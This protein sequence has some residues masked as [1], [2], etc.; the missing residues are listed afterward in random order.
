MVA[1]SLDSAHGIVIVV[2][3]NCRATENMDILHLGEF[4][5]LLGCPVAA[6]LAV[7][8]S[9]MNPDAP[10]AAELDALSIELITGKTVGAAEGGQHVQYAQLV[11]T[12]GLTEDP[13][14]I[15]CDLI[16]S[17]SGWNPNVHLHS[18]SGAKPA[19]DAIRWQPNS[20]PCQSS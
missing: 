15:D 6:G 20:M 18:Q 10:L 9:R 16:A 19:Y 8:D 1:D 11:S 5:R 7:V 14:R 2:A 12:Q 13:Q 3:K 4:L 17:S